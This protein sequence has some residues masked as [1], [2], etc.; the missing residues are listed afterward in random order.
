[1]R[2][3]CTI[4]FLLG[5]SIS[6]VLLGASHLTGM[7]LW[8][9]S[10]L[11]RW[12]HILWPFASIFGAFDVDLGRGAIVGLFGLAI[13]GNGLLYAGLGAVAFGLDRL[14]DRIGR[15]GPGSI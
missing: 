7:Q 8:N 10:A 12:A 13:G 5:V 2:W 6:G 1:M 11:G 15:A 9:G 4:G 3:Y 14:I